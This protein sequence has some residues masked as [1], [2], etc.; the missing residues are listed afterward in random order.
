MMIL[1]IPVAIAVDLPRLL[2]QVSCC[3]VR[4]I[5]LLA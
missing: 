4:E 2:R 1:L 5:R 3:L